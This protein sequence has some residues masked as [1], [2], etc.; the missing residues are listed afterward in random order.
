M[1]TEIFTVL[2]VIIILYF[3]FYLGIKLRKHY[4]KSNEDYLKQEQTNNKEITKQALN[5]VSSVAGI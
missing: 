2:A 1:W 5:T 4:Y 3:A